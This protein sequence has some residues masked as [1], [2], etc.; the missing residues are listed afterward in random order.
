MLT[1]LIEFIQ[2]LLRGWLRFVL[3]LIILPAIYAGLILF[4]YHP[5]KM[6]DTYIVLFL[7]NEHEWP[8]FPFEIIGWGLLFLPP[9]VIAY[10]EWRM[11]RHKIFN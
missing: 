6:F 9:I 1:R 2:Y 7:I 5:D 4:G 10:I 3:R 8:E 11:L